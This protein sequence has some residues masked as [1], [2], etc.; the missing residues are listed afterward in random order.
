VGHL[1]V[2]RMG[3]EGAAQSH[4]QT[5]RRLVPEKEL[6]IFRIAQE[7]L[8]NVRHSGA[9]LV[10]VTIDFGEEALTLIISDNGRG[11]DLE[12]VLRGDGS[13]T[14]W[15]LLGIQERAALLG[16]QYELDSAPGRGTYIRVQV[17]LIREAEDV[18]DTPVAG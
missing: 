8:N 17:P 13:H 1:D 10:E 7:A 4:R 18:E 2:L 16:G 3:E 9:S 14:G 12:Q 6:T 15:G 11:F 5:Q